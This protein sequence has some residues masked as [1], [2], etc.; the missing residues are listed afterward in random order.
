MDYTKLLAQRAVDMK[1]SGIRK[2]FDLV[3]EIPDC[4]SLSVGEP[5]FKT[6]WDIRDAAIHTIELG[7]TQYTTNAGLK[8][9]RLAIRE[10]LLRKYN[11]DYEIDQMIATVG[12]S[13]GIDLVFRTIVEEGD[14]VILPD[15]GYVTYQPTAAFAGASIK[16]V[17]AKVENDFRIQAADIKAAITDK[18]KAILLSYPNNPTGAILSR[19]EME[20]IAEVLR[21][22]N[23]LV[24]SDVI[25]SDLIY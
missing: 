22:T 4:I 10:Y 18:T 7:K 8:E 5:D 19:K 9:L 11:L 1:P 6:P 13:E 15:P 14:E 3:A 24:I 21:D 25:Y 2:F 16:Y 20:E 17:K 12:A 23:I